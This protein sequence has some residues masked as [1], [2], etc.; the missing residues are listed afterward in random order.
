MNYDAHARGSYDE[1]A[2]PYLNFNSSA[3]RVTSYQ[4]SRGSTGIKFDVEISSLYEITTS[5]LNSIFIMFG[6]RKSQA[7]LSRLGQPGRSYQYLVSTNVPHLEV[8]EWDPPDVPVFLLIEN[9]EGELVEKLEVG[10]FTY[11]DEVSKRT[12]LGLDSGE[13][14][15]PERPQAL[16]IKQQDYA[17]YS[18]M[19]GELYG[20]YTPQMQ[21]G[22]T[23]DGL[24]SQYGR[25]N[26][27]YQPLSSNRPIQQYSTSSPPSAIKAPWNSYN[28]PQA[29]H[30]QRPSSL[31]SAHRTS[32]PSISPN[33]RLVRTSTLDPTRNPAGTAFTQAGQFYHQAMHPLTVVLNFQ[34]DLDSMGRLAT[35][36]TEELQARRRILHC[37]RSQS[38]NVI[39]I[40]LRP[41]TLEE[42]PPNSV[43]IS[44]ILW[45]EKN[46]CFVT[47]V[48][49][50]YLLEH[51][52]AQKFPTEE[53]NRI[54]RN[55][56]HFKPL[57]VKKPA[58]DKY[59]A[60]NTFFA[61]IMGFPQPKPRNIE[62]DIK[63]FAWKSLSNALKKI[64]SKY[65]S[66]A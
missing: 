64:T 14:R 11:D 28:N 27:I 34:S 10:D 31:A 57:T 52:M 13:I 32:L 19:P 45:E 65:V 16:G 60:S 8:A 54:R 53:K 9:S 1:Q 36:S 37:K 15:D 63:I 6:P 48:D 7:S 3:I 30:T 66:H 17:E 43:C 33:P 59:D 24:S 22:Q 58:S 20:T 49:T 2:T 46:Q 56:E 47:S 55:L 42:R 61:T 50:I 35:W 21:F 44:C 39:N 18:Y 41:V 5:N 40:K 12:K 38:G 26:S 4:P 51:I 23:Y 62:K 25:S 29:N